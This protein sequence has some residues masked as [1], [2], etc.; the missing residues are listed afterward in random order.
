MNTVYC[1]SVD[2]P[3]GTE[4]TDDI[5]SESGTESTP[6]IYTYKKVNK[7][8]TF[9]SGLGKKRMMEGALQF[10]EGT[11]QPLSFL[12]RKSPKKMETLEV[13]SFSSLL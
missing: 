5:G 7:S 2:S 1:H 6:S 4:T 3:T 13:S 8:R 12:P 10:K 11:N 9:L